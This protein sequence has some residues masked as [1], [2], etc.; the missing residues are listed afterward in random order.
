MLTKLTIVAAV[1]ILALTRPV[2]SEGLTAEL[3]VARVPTLIERRAPVP[4]PAATTTEHHLT[5][6][7]KFTHIDDGTEQQDKPDRR[8][9]AHRSR[10]GRATASKLKGRKETR[11]RQ[12]LRPRGKQV[13]PRGEEA[14]GQ[15]CAAEAPGSVGRRSSSARFVQMRRGPARITL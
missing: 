9:A 1:A 10:G 2:I 6:S 13:L 15:G 14:D 8:H 5:F 7:A 12:R 4:A 3:D 11:S